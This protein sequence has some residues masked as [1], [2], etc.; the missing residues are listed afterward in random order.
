MLVS[1]RQWHMFI[2][3]GY[4]MKSHKKS[5]SIKTIFLTGF[6]LIL[7]SVAIFFLFIYH[8]AKVNINRTFVPIENLSKKTGEEPGFIYD[9]PICF[10][11]IGLDTRSE[12]FLGRADALILITINPQIKRTT[13]ISIPRDTFIDS[14]VNPVN[15][16][17]KINATYVKGG[18]GGLLTSVNQLINIDIDYY[19]KINFSGLERLIDATGG[20]T[21]NSEIDFS[22]NNINFNKGKNTLSGKEALAYVRMRYDDPKGTYGREQRQKEVLAA[23]IKQLKIPKP[24]PVYN[25]IFE[26]V[27]D[28]VKTDLS[29]NQ[30][31]SIV[32]NNYESFGNIKFDSMQGKST[33]INDLS[34]EVISHQEI[35][36][37]HNLVKNELEKK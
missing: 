6:S 5:R 34:F 11:L 9:R 19:V 36:R 2:R 23:I 20:V 10:L 15:E 4:F 22:V 35:N 17:N 33:I 32:I 18:V 31:I 8:T 1:E 28:S 16:F 21:I 37:I 30:I 26:S 24:I 25:S 14:Q 12:D 27:G 7:F 13:M 29:W 3:K